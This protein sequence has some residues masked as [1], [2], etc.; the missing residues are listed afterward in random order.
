MAS[1]DDTFTRLPIIITLT[2]TIRGKIAFSLGNLLALAVSLGFAFMFA[3]L[4]S[5]FSYFHIIAA[6]LILLIAFTSYFDP[7]AL[8]RKSQQ[9]EKKAISVP[10]KQKYRFVWLFWAG[11]VLSFLTLIDDTLVFV[12]FFNGDLVWNTALLAGVFV[13]TLIQLAFVVTSAELMM[14]IPYVREFC[15]VSLLF[16]GVF[17]L[18]GIV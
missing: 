3:E 13:S 11:F 15:F 2:S 12:P 4:F 18:L 17:V 14:R 1:I 5:S 8:R 7:F 6:V 10:I 16:L 9:G